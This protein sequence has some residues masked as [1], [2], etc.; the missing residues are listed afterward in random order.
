MGLQNRL[1]GQYEQRGEDMQPP[2]MTQPAEKEGNVPI[3]RRNI[4]RNHPSDLIVRTRGNN[5]GKHP[6][7]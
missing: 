3:T 7:Q 1:T 4:A 5:D 6:G 2:S